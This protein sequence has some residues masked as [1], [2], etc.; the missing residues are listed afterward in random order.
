LQL[1]LEHVKE[2]LTS[3]PQREDQLQ[4]QYKAILDEF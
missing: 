1:F 2:V 4:T 3:T